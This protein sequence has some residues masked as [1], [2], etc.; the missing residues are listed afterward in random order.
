MMRSRLPRCQ[1]LAATCAIF[2][3]VTRTMIVPTE[4]TQNGSVSLSRFGRPLRSQVQ[5]VMK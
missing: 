2:V 5:R 3:A 1:S 4:M